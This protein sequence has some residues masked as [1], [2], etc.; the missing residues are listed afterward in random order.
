MLK[1]DFSRQRKIF[2]G[3]NFIVVLWTV[4]SIFRVVIS[5]N[6]NPG[7]ISSSEIV[8]III[9]L[10]FMAVLNLF[11]GITLFFPQKKNTMWILSILVVATTLVTLNFF[12]TKLEKAEAETKE[13]YDVVREY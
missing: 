5:I 7:I 2:G 3:T 12:Q 13:V 9:P 6:R 8:I 11:L 1:P 10:I 4:L